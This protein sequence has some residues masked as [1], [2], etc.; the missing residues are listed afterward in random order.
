MKKEVI[1]EKYAECFRSYVTSQKKT[2]ISI[3]V[4]VLIGCIAL[5]K[6]FD[7]M[8]SY[9]GAEHLIKEMVKQ[10]E[11][12]FLTIAPCENYD[13]PTQIEQ[14]TIGDFYF[15]IVDSRYIIDP[16]LIENLLVGLPGEKS[17]PAFECSWPR[18]GV[19]MVNDPDSFLLICFECSNFYYQS[20]SSKGH[21]LITL[22]K[23]GPYKDLFEK[24]VEEY[25]MIPPPENCDE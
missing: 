2:K 6:L 15:T 9:P 14:E 20:D 22:S 3:A 5:W 8:N 25:N 16:K 10:G 12:E 24:L 19:R 18:H 7:R 4:A 23:M 1:E 11:I 21:G 17:D 13:H